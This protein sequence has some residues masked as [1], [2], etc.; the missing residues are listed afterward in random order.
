MTQKENMH[1]VPVWFIW[2][3]FL[4]S[5]FLGISV[6]AIF[7][8]YVPLEPSIYSIGG[9]IM[10][11]G[12]LIVA[13][14]YRVILNATWFFRI[15]L[16]NELVLLVAIGYF[17][18]YSYQYQTALIVYIGYQITFTFG[19]YLVRA[20]TLLLASDKLLTQVDTAKQLGYL[21]GMIFAYLFYKLLSHWS[22]ENNQEKVYTLHVLLII[23]ELAI[24]VLIFKSFT[25]SS[26]NQSN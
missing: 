18:L 10:A 16:V 3:K 21:I 22:I 4:N 2:Y 12:M 15:S 25:K 23:I 26:P 11:V 1:I 13:Q 7:T 8:I 17:L 19:S 24:I 20:E 9:I 14:L 6:G 5:F